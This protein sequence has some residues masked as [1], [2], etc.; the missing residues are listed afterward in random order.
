MISIPVRLWIP[1]EVKI[2]NYHIYT[3]CTCCQPT[4]TVKFETPIFEGEIEA[5][6]YANG[7]IIEVEEGHI[8]GSY[9]YTSNLEWTW[10]HFEF[11]FKNQE[12]L[13]QLFQ[14]I[15]SGE[16]LL[17]EAKTRK[18]LPK[19]LPPSFRDGYGPAVYKDIMNAY[20]RLFG[21]PTQALVST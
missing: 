5:E 16:P 11:P 2:L 21:K 19:D 18:T 1:P 15:L 12:E 7:K 8:S 17:K 20:K 9:K 6:I 3:G 13:E 10:N 4:L 14:R